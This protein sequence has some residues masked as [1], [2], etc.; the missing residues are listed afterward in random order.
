MNSY[1]EWC[2]YL[3]HSNGSNSSIPDNVANFYVLCKITCKH[4]ERE[5]CLDTYL[6]V[7]RQYICVLFTVRNMTAGERR[8]QPR[9]H[10]WNLWECDDCLQRHPHVQRHLC[11]V[12]RYVSSDILYSAQYVYSKILIDIVHSVR[13][14]CLHLCL[15]ISLYTQ[16]LDGIYCTCTKIQYLER[17]A[18][19]EP[20][21]A[22]AGSNHHGQGKYPPPPPH[23][24]RWAP[25]PYTACSA[26]LPIKA[27]CWT[28][29]QSFPSVFPSLCAYCD[30]LY[31]L[32]IFWGI[33][34]CFF[35]YYIQH[36][37]ICRPSDSTVP[38]DAGIE[39][40]TVATGALAVR[41][42]NH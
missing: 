23:W 3:V 31:F 6:L 24:V 21:V 34:L 32:N 29:T 8:G 27:E 9:G 18:Y 2:S 35:P 12:R 5:K 39:P 42:S 36:C 16:L 17:C 41:R 1:N 33:F 15:D 22:M 25:Y 19:S 14:T 20:P 13:G 7:S 38:T 11:T 40:R 37:F 26:K 30:G 10:L 4:W 28:I